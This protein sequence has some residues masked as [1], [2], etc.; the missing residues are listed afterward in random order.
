MGLRGRAARLAAR[1]RSALAPPAAPPFF[2]A[3]WYRA[4]HPDVARAGFDPW[5]H[6]RDHGRAEGRAPAPLD[7][8]LA[9]GDLW[10]GFP[11]GARERLEALAHG[12][13]PG[14]RIL[15]AWALA[16]W[17]AARGE[18]I[19]AAD[20][21]RAMRAEPGA[22]VLVEGPG[23]A[24]LAAR[25]FA[26]HG[27]PAEARVALNALRPSPD[28]R[29]AEA[30]AERALGA[31]PAA[32]VAALSE[33]F[34]GAGLW[35]LALDEG[36]GAPIDRLRA[37]APRGPRRR[38]PSDPPL[39]SVIVP[40]RDA[41]RTLPT[42]LRSLTAQS[43]PAIEV[44]VVE[45]GSRDG[46]LAV[47]EAEAQ[48]D[49]RIRVLRSEEVGA[50]PA[51]NL[52]LAEARGAFVTVHD[53]DDWSHPRKTEAQMRPHLGPR[54]P[55]ATA[56]H[57]VRVTPDL[58]LSVW[59]QEEGFVH[60]NTSSLLFRTE[61]RER[62][63][64]WDRVRVSADTELYFRIRA[65]FGDG[66]VEE[67]LPGVPL[68]LAR[69]TPASLTQRRG[70]ELATQT[71]GVRRTYHEAALRWHARMGPGGL[72]LPRR[73]ERR[74]FDAPDAIA[75]GDPPPALGPDDRVRRSPL[76]DARWYLETYE[77][78][79]R[80]EM[81]A[82]LHYVEDGAA[83]GRDPG[84]GFSSSGWRAARGLAG[85]A[86]PVL[87]YEDHGRGRSADPLPRIPGRRPQ[88]AP[89]ALVF[90]HAA[91]ATLFGAERSLLDMLDRL[92]AEGL[93][94]VVVLPRIL[95]DGYRD[96]VLARAEAL[97]VVPYRWWHAER[98]AHPVTLAALRRIVAREG[99]REVHVNTLV[100]DA[101]LIAA[102]A[103]GV[104][105]V[106]HVR[107][108]PGHD[109]AIRE[110]L[111]AE[112]PAIRARLL[113]GADRFVANSA[114]VAEWLDAPGRVSVRGNAVDPALLDLPPPPGGEPVRAALI[115]SNLAKKGV[116]DAVEIARRL[117]GLVEVRLVGPSTPDLDALE[118]LP[119]SAVRAGYAEGPVEAM[120]EADLVLSLSHF[121]E[122]FGRTVLEAMAAGRPVVAYDGGMPARLVA[123]GETGHV[124]PRGDVGAAAEAVAAL[125]RDPMRRAA[126]GRAGRERA[127]RLLAESAA[128]GGP[129]GDGTGP[130]G[131]AAKSARQAAAERS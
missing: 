72:H 114:L 87:D 19:A 75:M 2:D 43:W 127:R 64:F 52:G 119:P 95:N 96:A 18:W 23:P 109:P 36:P 112:A 21:L 35:A 129:M 60:R 17:H 80:T 101:P 62:L 97:H 25:A 74:P 123:D 26:R 58:D 120:A 91:D 56:S 76:F 15:A 40:A 88:G 82:A 53:A 37:I 89:R 99:P 11:A 77:D 121:A 65:A 20:H 48:R 83:G 84:P 100:I 44:L 30:D 102:R 49:G 81:D 34:A 107:E 1:A 33:I 54:P 32:T 90:G 103:E 27:S 13:S 93:S 5:A 45:N 39:V 63:G 110:A 117:D 73:P 51:R 69:V 16:R 131:Q 55:V 67:V 29:L 10:R 8:P 86:N 31:G 59:R 24:L 68:A 92:G 12:P 50:Y 38:P 6:W 28:R 130:L 94:P 22:G 125:A 46:T 41:E 124:V 113:A 71:W 115:G 70:T 128:A 104:P 78:V 42:A 105:S 106:V 61:L 85:D 9:E 79:R 4:R 66:A 116:A 3:E 108:M 122:S 126:M 14:E 47:A 118:P 111:G 57:L 98:E 7:A